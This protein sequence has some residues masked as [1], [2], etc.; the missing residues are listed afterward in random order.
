MSLMTRVSVL[1]D[2]AGIAISAGGW[3]QLAQERVDL[4]VVSGMREVGLQHSQLDVLAQHLA[5]VVNEA[6]IPVFEQM[7][8]TFRDLGVVARGAV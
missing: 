7:L 4:A 3:P 6:T 5:N 2:V 1:A 8:W